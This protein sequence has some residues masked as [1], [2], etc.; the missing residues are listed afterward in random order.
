MGMSTFG[1]NLKIERERM[2]LNQKQ[3]AQKIHTSQQ[4]VSEWERDKVEPTV[5]NIVAIVHALDISF[6]DLF[7][8]IDL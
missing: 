8:G 1:Q 6:D 2:G 3:L 4:R 7:D 5:S